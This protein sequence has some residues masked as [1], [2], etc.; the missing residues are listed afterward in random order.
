[1][2]HRRILN[3]KFKHRITK[4]NYTIIVKVKLKYKFLKPNN[5]KLFNFKFIYN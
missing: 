2:K 3:A 5:Y 4:A 1:M